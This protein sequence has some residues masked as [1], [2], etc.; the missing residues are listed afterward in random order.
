MK[1]TSED[2]IGQLSAVIDPAL[3]QAAVESYVDMEGRFLVGDH[4]PAE[5]NGGRLCEAVSRSLL[6]LDIGKVNHRLLPGRVCE[7]LVDEQQQHAHAMNGG[8]RRHI[9][10]AIG[11][12]YKF[13]SDRGAVHIS[14]DYSANFMDSMLMLHSG[15]WTFAELLR[16]ALKQD[17][18]WVAEAIKQ[19]VQLEHAIIHE[20]EGK[21]LV[22]IP[23]IAAP[24]EVLLLLFHANGKRLGRAQL[25][26]FAANQKPATVSTA[27]SRLIAD[28]ALRPLGEAEVM[29]TP[30]GEKR[31][32]E[33]IMPKYPR[34]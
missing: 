14:P 27:V 1:I 16:L 19:I 3:A 33:V 5:L 34:I 8:D 32:V 22:L 21:P 7:I 4:G 2:L 31:V 15:K 20:V 18:K 23:G 10:K 25:R 30:V 26:D 29:L 6:Q 17:L 13:R 11:L 9:A 24:E 28:K 12:V